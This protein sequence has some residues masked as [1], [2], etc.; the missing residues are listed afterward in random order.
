MEKAVLVQGLGGAN[1]EIRELS[2][3]HSD[4]EKQKAIKGYQ[5]YLDGV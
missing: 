5:D 1:L 2:D 3:R 4:A